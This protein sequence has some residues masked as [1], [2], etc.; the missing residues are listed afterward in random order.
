MGRRKSPAG[1]Q[2]RDLFNAC[3]AD[4]PVRDQRDMMERPFFG[5]GKKPRHE[6]IVYQVAE[7]YVRVSPNKE[8]GIASIWDA[9]ILI[10]A[11]TQI[12]EALDRGLRPD[13]TIHFHPYN[14]L[15]GIRRDTSG[16]AYALHRPYQ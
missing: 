11:A 10:W 8:Y 4:I 1:D 13:R 9:D 2:Q 15:K 16:R 6:P 5:L 7:V 14:L 3:F 12:R